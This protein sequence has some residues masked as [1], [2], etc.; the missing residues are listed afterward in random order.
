M[1][2]PP[3]QLNYDLLLGPLFLP[4]PLHGELAAA[5]VTLPRAGREQWCGPGLYRRRTMAS[6]HQRNSVRILSTRERGSQAF[7]SQRLLQQ[8][9]EE[10]VRWMKWQSQVTAKDD[11]LSQLRD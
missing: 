8:M 4:Q 5:E 2:T 11:P 6:R 3:Q 1:P 7:G 10:K 9:V